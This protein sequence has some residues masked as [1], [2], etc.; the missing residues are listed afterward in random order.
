MLRVPIVFKAKLY[1]HAFSNGK[2]ICVC[3]ESDM[4]YSYMQMINK[5][6]HWPNNATQMQILFALLGP[7]AHACYAL[8]HSSQGLELTGSFPS[9]GSVACGACCAAGGSGRARVPLPRG[10]AGRREKVVPDARRCFCAAAAA[11]HG[12]ASFNFIISPKVLYTTLCLPASFPVSSVCSQHPCFYAV[13]L[14]GGVPGWH[15]F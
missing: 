7:L 13:A 15:V 5:S 1:E 2:F 12:V 10:G 9:I 11:A 4:Y 8:F 3:Y 14:I 6:W